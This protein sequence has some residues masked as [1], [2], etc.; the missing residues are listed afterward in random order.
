MNEEVVFQFSTTTAILLLLG[1]YGLTF[2][3]SLAL[4]GAIV[5]PVIA[6]FYWD[7]V[8]NSAF[9]GAVVSALVLFTIVRFELV[10]IEGVTA[11]F[12]EVVAAVGAGIV[13]GL[14]AFAFVSRAAAIVVGVATA[15]VLVPFCVGFLRD[16]I[17][18]LSSLT[19][20]SVSTIVCVAVSL[21]GRERFDFAQLAE[22]VTSFQQDGTGRSQRTQPA[23][24]GERAMAP[25]R[26]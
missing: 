26:L 15:V 5:F 12:F 3:M 9:T 20:Y 24:F 25:A 13:I 17:V 8:T 23:S 10:P 7:R 4:W 1:F 18:L 19:A 16:Y 11:V 6:S 14:M 2:I 21:L 22:R